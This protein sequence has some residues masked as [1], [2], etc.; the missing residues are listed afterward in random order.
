MAS[1]YVLGNLLQKRLSFEISATCANSGRALEIALDSD[2][3][4]SHVTPGADP[5]FCFPIVPIAKTKDPS[6]VD[7]F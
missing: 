5:M 6:I 4:I 1:P 7:I 3:N 2:L